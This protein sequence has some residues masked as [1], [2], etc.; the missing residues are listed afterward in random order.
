MTVSVSLL[1]FF[2]SRPA[3]RACGNASMNRPK[4]VMAHLQ[5]AFIFL[6]SAVE[7]DLFLVPIR[8]SWSVHRFWGEIK[9]GEQIREW[10]RGRG[11][12]LR[13]AT[14]SSMV[15]RVQIFTAITAACAFNT[16]V[17][18]RGKERGACPAD[19]SSLQNSASAGKP[20]EVDKQF[21]NTVHPDRAGRRDIN[22]VIK[23]PY[24]TGREAHIA[25][26]TA[27]PWQRANNPVTWLGR[28]GPK[29]RE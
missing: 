10:N 5:T 4:L 13:P 27:S 25:H 26:V 3:V 7:F 2:S 6:I 17:S 20:R 24:C 21:N 14:T 9:A 22:F 1:P 23:H 15:L 11:G 19:P 12:P 29:W 18:S 28:R 16:A 8:D